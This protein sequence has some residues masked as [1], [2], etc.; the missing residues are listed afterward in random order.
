MG[1]RE[2][3]RAERRKRKRRSTERTDAP[4]AAA[5]GDAGEPVG[6]QPERFQDRIAK[7]SEERNAEVRAGLEPLAEGERPGA[8]T[9]ATAVSA[10]LASIF[11]ISAVVAAFRAIEISG[12]EPSPAPLAIFAA[13]LWLMTWGLWK[14]RYWAVLGFQ[15]L[16]VLFMLSSALGLV[17]VTTILQL[18]GTLAL[19][20][21]SGALFYFMIRAMARIQMPERPQDR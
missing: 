17:G 11:T 3:K 6:E 7:R 1:S 9:V 8:V 14:A 16:L 12:E 15:M 5:A 20:L 21:G 10:V 2:R 18:V 19:L 13:A 4:P